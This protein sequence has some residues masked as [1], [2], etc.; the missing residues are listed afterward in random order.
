MVFSWIL[1]AMSKEIV[2]S[3]I[4]ADS[5]KALYMNEVEDRFGESNA[6]LIYQI[7]REL[8]VTVQGGMSVTQYCTKLK[9]LWDEL[10]SLESL[11][12]CNCGATKAMS[13]VMESRKIMQFL[14]VLNEEFDSSKDHILL[15]EPFPAVSKVFSL[16]L[17]VENRVTQASHP[18]AM[19]MTTLSARTHNHFGNCSSY[20]RGTQR[21]ERGVMFNA[22]GYMGVHGGR[23]TLRRMDDPRKEKE[24]LIC[25]HCNRMG[26]LWI[27][28]FDFTDFQ[29]G[30][31]F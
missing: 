10:S 20:M 8:N 28:V 3:F 23:G 13:D 24:N 26:I 1:N 22:N 9:K 6:P 29:I 19:N 27:L 2:G 5:A 18:D 25:E 12:T 4:Y 14:M 15:M 30:T 31:K 11:P 21:Q 17:K 16:L 7:R